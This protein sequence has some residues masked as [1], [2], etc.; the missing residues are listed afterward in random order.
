[1]AFQNGNMSAVRRICSDYQRFEKDKADGLFPNMWMFY[2]ED[3]IFEC[4][5]LLIGPKKTVF[6]GALLYFYVNYPPDYPLRSPKVKFLTP[7]MSGN[8]KTRIHPNLYAEGKVCLSILG[9]WSGEPWSPCMD[10]ISVFNNITGLL[11]NNPIVHE[12]GYDRAPKEER[13]G[14]KICTRYE[15]VKMSCDFHRKSKEL[16]PKDV[17]RVIHRAFKDNKAQYQKH[18]DRLEKY[19]GTKYN[20]LH[21]NLKI[22]HAVLVNLLNK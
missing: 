10:I 20:L 21:K 16:L 19:D 14:Y 13:T 12:P 22:K 5:V 8:I 17:Y 3:N 1:M 4:Y 6:A 11:D 15:I 18:I 2:N 9:T 7:K